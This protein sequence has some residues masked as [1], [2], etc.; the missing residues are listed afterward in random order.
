MGLTSVE[1]K[2]YKFRRYALSLLAIL[3]SFFKT[4]WAVT[5]KL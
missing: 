3:I 5:V 1:N 4:Q 2:V